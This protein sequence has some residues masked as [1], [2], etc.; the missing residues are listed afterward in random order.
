MVELTYI[1][2]GIIIL[3]IRFAMTMICYSRGCLQ[4]LI[5]VAREETEP[6]MNPQC[7][8]AFILVI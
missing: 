8:I 1:V 5:C 4:N 6:S 7:I 3:C 2:T